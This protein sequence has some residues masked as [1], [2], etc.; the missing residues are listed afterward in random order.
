[1]LSSKGRLPVAEECSLLI[2]LTNPREP[3][4]EVT[5]LT[6]RMVFINSAQHPLL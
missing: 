1:M 5:W 2:L 6:Q 3:F 4:K